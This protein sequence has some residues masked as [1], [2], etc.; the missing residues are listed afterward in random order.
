[1]KTKI[2]NSF[3][4]FSTTI[5]TSLC[6]SQSPSMSWHNLYGGSGLEQFSCLDFTTDDGYILGGYATSSNGD[7]SENQG[8]EDYWIVKVDAEGTLLWEKSYGGSSL[9]VV[10]KIKQTSDGGYIVAEQPSPMMVMCLVTMLKETPG[11]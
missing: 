9:D 3:L 2:Y 5:Y 1:M 11:S 4:F 8:N 7:V 10:R 6:L